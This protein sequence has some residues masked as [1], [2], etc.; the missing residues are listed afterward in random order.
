MHRTIQ[1]LI[2]I[3]RRNQ[4]YN[5]QILYLISFYAKTIKEISDEFKNWRKNFQDQNWDHALQ[6]EC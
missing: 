4:L 1:V 2:S 3:T 6:F 5:A